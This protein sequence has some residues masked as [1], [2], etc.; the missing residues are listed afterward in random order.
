M[1]LPLV[2]VVPSKVVGVEG[3]GD[4]LFIWFMGHGTV[5]GEVIGMV[6]DEDLTSGARAS[7]C[8][9]TGIWAA[10]VGRM[11]VNDEGER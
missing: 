5:R 10:C 3:T 8:R 1:A 6:N 2:V 11:R 4:E 7:D 9:R